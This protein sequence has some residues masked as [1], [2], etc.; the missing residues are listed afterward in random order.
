MTTDWSIIIPE[1]G[2]NKVKN[3][4]AM[5]AGNYAAIG[6][7]VS[8]SRSTIISAYLGYTTWRI[9]TDAVDEGIHLDLLLPLA[10]AIHYVT[11]R[12]NTV[13]GT[14]VNVPQIS[15]NDVNFYTPALI[16]TEG[17]WQVYGTQV[18]GAHSV[19]STGI[20]IICKDAADTI[21]IGHVQ[22]EQRTAPTTPIT[23]DIRGFAKNGYYWLGAPHA[24]AS[25][26]ASFERSGGG[27]HDLDTEYKFT[28][29]YGVGSGMPPIT[30]HVQG[31]VLLPGALYQ[32]HKIEPRVLDLVSA[33]KANTPALVAHAR[34]DFINAV[35]PDLVS[36]EQPVVFRYKS[37]NNNKPVDFYTYY[38]SGMEFNLAHGKVDEPTPRF[39]AY[40][41]FVYEV[42]TQS[43]ELTTIVGLPDSD[44]IVRKVNGTWSNISTDFNG[45]VF[46][47][48]RGMD[49]CIY[50]GGTFDAGAAAN[51]LVR[52]NPYTLALS[53][54]TGGA[55]S[56]TNDFVTTLVTAANGDIYFGGAF[57]LAGA[58]ANTVHIAYWDISASEF[59]ALGVGLSGGCYC[60]AIAPTGKLYI[61]GDFL[62]QGDP[63]GDY[64]TVWDGAG[65][66]SL[67]TGMNGP[68]SALA[69]APNGDIF[70]TGAFTL[71][72]GVAGTA[73]IARWG[74]NDTVPAWHPLGTG[75]SGGTP[76]GYALAIDKAG[77]VI[78]A[79]DFTHADG[80]ACANIAMWNGKTFVPL[81]SGLNDECASLAFDSNGLLIA[82]GNFTMAGGISLSDK[83][84]VW[85]YTT[86]AHVDINLPG[87]PYV[88]TVFSANN[89]LYLGYDTAG[90]AYTSVLN[91][92]TNSGSASA[93]PIFKIKRTVGSFA[94]LEWI[95][96][97]TTGDTLWCNYS[98]LDNE[99]L[100]ID[101][102]PGNRSIKSD[103]LGDVW[104]AILRSSDLSAF[105]LLP[106]VNNVS[107]FCNTDAT[108]AC[109]FEF[110]LIH[111]S[112]DMV[113]A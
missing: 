106:G 12:I 76:A 52:W 67:G 105:K 112:S 30:H 81:G 36:P 96:N 71:A 18:T 64:I 33:T 102:T 29:K 58:I 2:T 24:S 90:I 74:T 13:S 50:I 108:I 28:M 19:G 97:E 9:E 25:V 40:D 34:K 93:Y 85:N 53:Q 77:N 3:P 46:A 41:P 4:I 47:L 66:S 56:G 62:N 101:L 23:G 111:W 8:I 70:A 42:H 98:L 1:E 103:F 83:V 31:M 37:P 48:T 16:A 20:H 39:I 5:G 95:K 80:V 79:G 22:V 89:D 35:K 32:G 78:V 59:V 43:K 87:A 14:W 6:T 17:D 84:A 63:N 27:E 94:T 61:G 107:V 26:R 104:R 60:L 57:H 51:H 11:Y 75:L 100:T 99:T 92:T 88:Y 82:G 21:Y 73:H 15:L 55:G 44:Y 68:V 109:W 38:D 10:N 113:S 7:P 72:G 69:V 110:P 45:S 65:Y 49:G 54:L 91:A 86:W